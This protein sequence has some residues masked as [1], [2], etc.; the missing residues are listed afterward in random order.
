MSAKTRLG[1]M[2]FLQYAIWGAWA[3]VL[4]V[5][6]LDDLGFTGFQAGAIYALLPLA[7]ILSPFIGGQLADRYFSSEKVIAFLQFTG[8]VLLIFCAQATSFATMAWIMFLYCLLYAPTL[9]LTNSVAM[10]NLKDSEKEFGTI[11]VWGTIGWIAA[12]LA[13][14]GW[15][16]A[17]GEGMLMGGD[18]LF[19]AGVFSIVMGLQALMLPKTPPSKE[20]VKPW[21]FLESLKMLKAKQFAIFVAIT[22]VVSTE[23]E[24]FYI[25]TAPFLQSESIGVS[26]ANLPAVM[27][28]AQVAEIFVMAFVL[29]WAL[30]LYGMRKTL[31][32]GVVAW[33]IRYVIFAIGG[34]PL[35]V[36]AS[37]ALHGFCYVFFFVAAFIYVDKVAPPDIRASAQSMIAIVALG[38]GRFLGSLFAG[39]VQEIFTTDMGTNWTGVFLVPC[40]LTMLCAVAFLLFF[41]E[42]PRSGETPVPA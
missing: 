14:S 29:S 25:L 39:K 23:L 5:Y 33:P 24:F 17:G 10:I 41:R 9:A 19:L 4:S 21:A 18:M 22:F 15:R 11:R 30:K 2:M 42:E 34:P 38:L 31:A 37:L 3:P 8:G 35:L 12:G 7:T 6:L 26:P 16:T 36:I 32:I 1:I 13:L 27:T 28:I 40:A 20:G